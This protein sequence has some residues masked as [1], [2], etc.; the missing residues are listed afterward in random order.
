MM[1]KTV[2]K[3]L[4]LLVS[5]CMLACLAFACLG[6]SACGGSA[7]LKDGTYTGQSSNF[8]G[9]AVE[10]AGYGV[11]TVTIKDG[12]ITECTFEAYE[13]DGTLKDENYGQS[14]SGNDN[15]Y[16]KAQFAVNSCPEYAKA[17]VEAGSIDGV[18]VISGATVM[19]DQF[20]EAVED[21]L[22]Q[23]R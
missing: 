3:G 8:E 16:L 20:Q 4:T 1:G 15:K 23:A 22:S 21:A 12:E 13:L 9:D 7:Q 10:G 5:L 14:L 6:L 18:D 17:L 19:H 2:N 11:A